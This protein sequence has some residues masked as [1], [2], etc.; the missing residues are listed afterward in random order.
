MAILFND[1]AS[2]RPDVPAVVD[3]AGR[4]LWPDYNRRVNRLIHHLRSLGIKPGERI[5]LLSGNRRE[6]YEVYGAAAHSGILVVP[7]NWHFA[8]EEVEYVVDNSESRL[9]I[10]DPEYDQTAAGVRVPR[11]AF[12]AAYE[13][14]LAA[15]SDAEPEAQALGGVMFYT[16]GTT[17]RPKG[18][19]STSS[20]TD[21]P[22]DIYK[23]MAA[24]MNSMGY[25][26][27]GRTLLCGPHYHSAQWAFTF[28]PLIGGSSIFV[29]R[30]F[31][32][33]ETL[34]LV[35]RYRIT[36][37][38]LVPTRTAVACRR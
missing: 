18:V 10:T 22:P 26:S 14:A 7:V 8:A 33:E 13:A 36:N 6:V 34:E 27:D 1:F 29:Q 25:A 9:V 15:S 17:G 11:L 30:K 28:F 35:D 2:Q 23:L 32:P 31:V 24:G 37:I 3:D 4:T 21:L 19:K 16:S 5:S 12:G 20:Q 38:H